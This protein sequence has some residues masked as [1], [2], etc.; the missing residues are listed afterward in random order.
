MYGLNDRKKQN[1]EGKKKEKI[2]TSNKIEIK[3]LWKEQAREIKPQLSGKRDTFKL[4]VSEGDQHMN[5]ILWRKKVNR[6]KRGGESIIVGK[7][8]EMSETENARER[9]TDLCG[10]KNA[11]T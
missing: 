5:A 8:G 2:K 3:K 4:W 6:E 1:I 7:D 11:R 10:Q 9:K